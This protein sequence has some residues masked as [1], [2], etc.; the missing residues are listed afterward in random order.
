VIRFEVYRSQSLD[1]KQVWRWRARA[2]NGRI[3]ADSAEG[4]STR[5]GAVR[6]LGVLIGGAPRLS[7]FEIVSS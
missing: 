6:G 7:E 5:R 3:I 4:Y 1:R 2:R